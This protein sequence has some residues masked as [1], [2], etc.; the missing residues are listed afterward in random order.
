MKK[1]PFL[2]AKQNRQRIFW[3]ETNP[4]LNSS[5]ISI[6]ISEV[7]PIRVCAGWKNLVHLCRLYYLSPLYPTYARKAELKQKNTTESYTQF[8]QKSFS[9]Y[10]SDL[11]PQSQHSNLT[12]YLLCWSECYPSVLV[13]FQAKISIY[14]TS[15][16]PKS[17]SV[18]SALTLF[19][20]LVKRP[21]SGNKDHIKLMKL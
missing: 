15:H 8:L 1:E 4:S 3:A 19:P 12:L 16:L 7:V 10:C 9:H 2:E 14:C 11:T 20:V 5:K 17:N 18:I 21:E 13:S 6:A